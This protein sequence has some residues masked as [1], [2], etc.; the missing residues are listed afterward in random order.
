MGKQAAKLQADALEKVV[1]GT[2]IQGPLKSVRSEVAS[3]LGTVETARP[4]MENRFS[5]TLSKTI[6]TSTAA[7]DQVEIE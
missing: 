2:P 1:E 6:D 5:E 3:V 7:M 4:E